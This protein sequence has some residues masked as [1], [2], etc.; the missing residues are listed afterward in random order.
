[1]AKKCK[2]HAKGQAYWCKHCKKEIKRNSTKGWIDSYCEST[3]KNVRLM[4]VKPPKKVH[5]PLEN[6]SVVVTLPPP[7]LLQNS[8]VE[9]ML[10]QGGTMDFSNKD[11]EGF[12]FRIR[13]L[14]YVNFEGAVLRNCIFDTCDMRSANFTGAKLVNTTFR[15]GTMR[16]T[17]FN[18]TKCVEYVTFFQMD[19]TNASF[20]EANG[21]TVEFNNC[22]MHNA[23]FRD[24][25]I[26]N[27][28]IKGCDLSGAK[29]IRY[30]SCSWH[31]MGE[32]G[33]AFMATRV[34]GSKQTRYHCG[35]F[36]GPEVSLIKYIDSRNRALKP[37]RM[38]A[39]MFLK[40]SVNAHVRKNI[41]W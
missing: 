13:N 1:M 18:R 33:R 41:E 22:V 29:N 12:T 4:K 14:S 21:D 11:I 40:E 35:C 31:S 16:N 9:E 6:L 8:E 25:R 36:S 38:K 32:I 34:F 39:M 5:R 15:F 27:Y 26:T 37:S 30:A 23:E 20:I 7:R 2:S 28:T 3:G 10:N 17:K 19:M 24:F